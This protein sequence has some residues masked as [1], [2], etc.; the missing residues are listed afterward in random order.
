MPQLFL[1]TAN[2]NQLITDT[3]RLYKVSYP[4]INLRLIL[5][6][7]SWNK[8]RSELHKQDIYESSR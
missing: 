3:T 5:T 6:G 2:I 8:T 7:Y 1:E 4:E